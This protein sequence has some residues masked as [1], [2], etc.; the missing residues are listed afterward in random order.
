MSASVFADEH[1]AFYYQDFDYMIK[2]LNDTDFITQSFLAYKV[3]FSTK[4]DPFL[5]RPATQNDFHSNPYVQ[6]FAFTPEEQQ[7]YIKC[8]EHLA[9]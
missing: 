5:M 4:Q 1:I 9:A 6:L 8:L 7:R 3:I 2:I